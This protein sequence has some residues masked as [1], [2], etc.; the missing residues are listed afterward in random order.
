[1][2]RWGREG[3]ALLAASLMFALAEA[4][5]AQ[6]LATTEEMVKQLSALDTS[7]DIDVAALRQ[8]V[9]DRI[10]SKANPAALK[11]PAVLPQLNAL[12]HLDLDIQFNPDSP[13][14]RPDSYRTLGRLADAISDP[15][16]LSFG[17]L[18]VGHVESSGRRDES[19]TLS[20]RRADS[21]RDVLVTTF[22]I[23]S[24]RVQA[25]GLG[26]EQLLDSQNP[27]SPVNQQIQ[28]LAVRK[29]P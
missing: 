9:I 22:R 24:K 18:I 27:K 5:V 11:R 1:M 17:F 26:E 14:I 16:L 3:I 29:G 6:S 25:I 8:Q 2:R 23:S 15:R 21:F 20:Q 10:K 13:V 28:V 7:A 12:P 19:L 4:A